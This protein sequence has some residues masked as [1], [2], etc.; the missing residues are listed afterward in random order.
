M[1]VPQHKAPLSVV[2]ALGLSQIVGYGTLYYSFS[3][4]APAIASELGLS[5][6][7]TFGTLSVALILGSLVAPKAGQLADRHGAGRI[8]AAGSVAASVSLMAV[9]LAP[10]WM[11][12]VAALIAME[13]A[14]SFVL[15]PTAFV[16]TVQA[17]PLGAQRSIT[18]LTLIAGFA[19]TLFWPFTSMLID[20]FGW[21]EIY[22]LFAA[23]NL[24]VALPI[25]VW[26][27]RHTVRQPSARL[28]SPDVP[29]EAANSDAPTP[30]RP[31]RAVFIVMMVGFAISGF[32]QSAILV[33]MVPML[34]A[35][36]AASSVLMVS[37]LFG[38]SQVAARLVNMMFGGRLAQSVLAIVSLVLLS[39]G[40]VTL[41]LGAPAN[42]GLA[43]FAVFFGMGSGLLS[44]VGGTLPLEV[45]GR[46]AYG[47][48]VG[49]MSAARQF[50][51]ALAPFA[52]SVVMV[53][54]SVQTAIA[55]VAVIAV[56]GLATFTLVARLAPA[57][58]AT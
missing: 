47:S 49:W 57:T 11:S 17:G 16:A 39:A 12:F 46:E 4:L 54:Y 29:V 38:P 31:V 44:I 52:F 14:A 51:S 35:L 53:G 3:I 8:M 36:G 22:F 58:P 15:Y 19:S 34:V 18:H 48:Y 7:A 13:L 26:V 1:H 32:V 9:A 37:T 33:H 42:A 41:A 45:F 43:L 21:R 24:L 5:L 56:V 55:M 50:S 6:E 23:M 27:G 30:S 40:L 28:V 20:N 25:H 2:A 10:N